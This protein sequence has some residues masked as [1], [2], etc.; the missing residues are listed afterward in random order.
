M[1]GVYKEH[2]YQAHLLC[3][4]GLLPDGRVVR[5]KTELNAGKVGFGTG[6]QS[7]NPLGVI[8]FKL[9]KVNDV[10]FDDSNSKDGTIAINP[11]YTTQKICGDGSGGSYWQ[12][13]KGMSIINSLPG[14]TKLVAYAFKNDA[15]KA[16]LLAGQK[17]FSIDG[18]MLGCKLEVVVELPI[19]ATGDLSFEVSAR[20]ERDTLEQEYNAGLTLKDTGTDLEISTDKKTAAEMRNN[21]I[22]GSN[23]IM[24]MS[25]GLICKKTEQA[26]NA[27]EISISG[28]TGWDPTGSFTYTVKRATI[29]ACES[30]YWDPTMAPFG[31]Y[32]VVSA[33]SKT[34]PGFMPLAMT[35][36]AVVAI[37]VGKQL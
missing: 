5:V 17:L 37:V 12:F 24:S 28:I 16:T 29:A 10:T 34:F 11:A 18:S 8:Q 27:S 14:G 35:S 25:R 1:L 21:T 4:S 26:V 6:W 31:G 20:I 33:G 36:V 15:D 3:E 9:K 2:S 7:A 19:P 30:L 13:D 32:E 22:K 23:V